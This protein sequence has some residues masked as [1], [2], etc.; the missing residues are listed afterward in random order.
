MR[1]RRPALIA[2]AICAVYVLLLANPVHRHVVGVFSDFYRW[3]A[4]D[5]DRISAGK[6]PQNTYNPPGYPA[7]LVMASPFTQDRFT[8]G[9]WMSL[10]AAGLTGL[11]AFHLHRRLFGAWPALLAMTI[12][13]SAETF[14]RYAVTAMTDIPFLCIA[15]G[16]M[17][18]I[19]AERPGWRSAIL[20]GALCGAAC[21][22]R[23]NGLFLLAPGLLAMLWRDSAWA[24]R[25]TRAALFL[26]SFLLVVAPWLALNYVQ[27]GSPV[28]STSHQDIARELAPQGDPQ[29]PETLTE[30]LRTDPVGVAGRYA[31]RVVLTLGLSLD[32][33][34]SLFPAGLLAVAGIAWALI[35][36]RRRP[37][38]LVLTGALAFLLLMSLTHWE[39]RYFFFLLVCYAGFA[40]FA[41]FEIARWI[42]RDLG[43]PIAARGVIAGLA[44]LILIPSTAA[45][46][47]TVNTTLARQPLELLPAA[48]YLDGAAPPGAT[49]M[50]PRAHLAYLS[51]REHRDLPQAGSID[52]LRDLLRERPP[53]YLVYDRWMRFNPRLAALA[54]SDGGIPWL[55]PVYVDPSNRVVIY[56]V[57][58]GARS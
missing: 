24:R 29:D 6:A 16:A 45:A 26:G 22:V 43:S 17:L 55:H 35:R 4:P 40:G 32:A 13:L 27:H 42:G 9:K 46:W 28:Y 7:L 36:D 11:L 39:V 18:V 21:L 41:V 49:V 23:Y 56:A 48:R 14:T 51:R 25:A 12:T 38:F 53:D 1:E 15:V 50:A 31:R 8:A 54:A 44:L 52:E 37:V 34:P 47:R 30:A 57:R 33:S 20:A 3:Y 2:V 58:L 5:A 10:F 19:T